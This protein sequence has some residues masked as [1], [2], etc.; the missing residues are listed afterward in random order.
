[1]NKTIPF[2]DLQLQYSL[3]RDD[4]ENA[5]RDVCC[6]GAFIL[7]PEVQRF[8]KLFADYLG[9][10][11]AIGVASGTDALRL[12]CQ[13]LE[14]GPGDE[15]L[16]PANTFIASALAVSEIGAKVI[17]VDV[18]TDSFLMDMELA[19][20]KITPHTKA[21][22]PVHL[23]GQSMDMDR[24]LA[25]AD[26]YNLKI[27]EDA[28][29]SHGAMWKKCRT[30]SFGEV[31]CFSFYPA[32]NLGAFGDG[33]IVVT[34]DQKI[35]DQLRLLRNYGSAKKNLHEIPGTNSRLDS[36]Q[37]AVLRVKIKFLDHWNH[38]RFRVACQYAEQLAGI[39]EIKVPVFNKEDSKR[40]V[41]H[42]FT[43]QCEDRDLLKTYL[44]DH[45]IQ[46]GIHYPTP[47]HLHGAFKSLGFKRGA[48]PIAEKLSN[49]ILSL[50]I[51]PEI[52]EVQISRVVDTIRQYYKR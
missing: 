22:M 19:K 46:C 33:G 44:N 13:A 17:P 39:Q 49:F 32:K 4:F 34:N 43:I 36:L 14:I 37:A 40:H 20:Q 29:Q 1:M 51:F 28:A 41:F 31:G 11:Y 27:I 18:D 30:G 21:I 52:E 8:E 16:I 45:G 24:V 9:V 5:I 12:S 15:V 23:F 2:V 7:G 48:F 50:P 35:A 42:L 6:S 3:Y 47:I 26:Q 38:Q 25:F 10:K